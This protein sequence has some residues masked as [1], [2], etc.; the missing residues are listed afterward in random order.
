MRDVLRGRQLARQEGLERRQVGGHAFQ[1]EVDLPVEHVALAHRGPALGQ[2]LEG[3]QVRLRLT[4][5]RHHREDAHLEA[6]PPRVERRVVAPDEPPLLERAHPAQAGRS[7]DPHPPRE[8]HVRHPPVGLQLREDA[9][10][11]RVEGGAGHR[12]APGRQGRRPYLPE[13]RRRGKVGGAARRGRA[14]AI[15]VIC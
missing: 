5:Q 13:R 3:A 15:T 4:R 8:L 10:V 2:R 7:A 11:E 9:A 14:G 12:G 6:K 1:E